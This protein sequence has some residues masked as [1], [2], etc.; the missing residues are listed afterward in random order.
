MVTAKTGCVIMN[1][2]DSTVLYYHKCN[3]CQASEIDRPLQETPFLKEGISEL[4]EY[5]CHKCGKTSP[6]ALKFML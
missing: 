4:G 2:K 1:V 6:V 5:T 3:H